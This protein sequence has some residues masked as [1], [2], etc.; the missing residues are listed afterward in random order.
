MLP[1]LNGLFAVLI[2]A[3]FGCGL[4]SL[5][6]FIRGV[7][8]NPAKPPGAVDRLRR[9]LASP[10]LSGR[11]AGGALVGVLALVLTHWPVAAGGLAALVIFWPQLFGGQRLEQSQILQLEALVMWTESVRDT[12]TA[13]ASL[14]Q[15]IP[16]TA[17]TAPPPIRP[18]LV[19]LTGLVRSRVP[20][21]R[22]LLALSADLNDGSADKVIGSLILNA[23]QRGT[24]LADVLTALAAS[25]RAE[26]DQRRRISA[27]RSSMRRSVQ[28][29]VVIT[30]GFAIFL[31]LFSRDYVK[32]YG[33]AGGQVALAVVVGLFAAAFMWMRKLA[34]G[35]PSAR[36]LIQPDERIPD[37]DLRVVG[38]LT[39]LSTAEAQELTANRPA[40][41]PMGD[42]R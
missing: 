4:V 1:S 28:I 21:D 11:I 19:R 24:G 40:G 30:I 33:S 20:L 17:Y 26:L 2:A 39:G 25:A 38:H 31:V 27:G 14:E 16:A 10:A 18:A 12:I 6:V 34:G 42:R 13:R 35:E 7:A 9:A 37:V 41:Q 3:G 15:A 23:R 32:P 36:F 29:V 5:A 22:A 8:P